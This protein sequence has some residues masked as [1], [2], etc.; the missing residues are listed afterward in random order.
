MTNILILLRNW[1][2]NWRHPV[3]LTPADVWR[4]RSELR[5]M[6]DDATGLPSA[7]LGEAGFVS[8]PPLYRRWHPYATANESSELKGD[9]T[10]DLVDTGVIHQVYYAG[11]FITA[12]AYL[13]EVA[14]WLEEGVMLTAIDKKQ[15]A[16]RLRQ[17]AKGEG[18]LNLDE[19]MPC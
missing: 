7:I 3:R 8:D 15:I 2:R 5:Q 6:A 17:I 11:A 19:R 13:D 12:P 1:Y 14:H 4:V 16:W 9:C 18:V 10:V